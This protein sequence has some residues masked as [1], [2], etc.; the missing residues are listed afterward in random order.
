M[1]TRTLLQ[2]RAFLLLLFR[3]PIRVLGMV[4]QVEGTRP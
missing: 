2:I 4:I 3:M 1:I